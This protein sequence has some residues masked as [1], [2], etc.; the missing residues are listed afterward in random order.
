M[1]WTQPM[2][3][4]APSIC[5]LGIAAAGLLLTRSADA[6]EQQWRLGGDGGFTI[7]GLPEGTLGGLLGGAHLTYGVSDA[8]NLRLNADTSWYALPAPATYAMLW[9]TSVGAEYVIDIMDWVPTLGMLVG[10]MG[11]LRKGGQTEQA[12]VEDRH[13]MYLGLEFSLGIGYQLTRAFTFGVEG[14]YRLLVVGSDVG[15]ITSL[16]ALARAEY[17]WE[18]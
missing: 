15:P 3:R 11:I 5:A 8:F 16:C 18:L 1:W 7:V 12:L 17:V 9:N 10:P 2:R 4:A 6:T 14:R 13:D